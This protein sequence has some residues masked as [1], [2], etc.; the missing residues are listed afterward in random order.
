VEIVVL[1]D[2]VVPEGE[3]RELIAGLRTWFPRAMIVYVAGAH[4]SSVERMAR[5]SGV[6]SYTAKPVDVARVERLL[7]CLS[8]RRLEPHPT[9]PR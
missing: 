6:L 7:S 1:D 4:G 8:H 5:A 9:I 3:R 2:D